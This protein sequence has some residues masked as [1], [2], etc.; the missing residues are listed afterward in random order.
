[1]LL[2]CAA[3]V[4]AG[5]VAYCDDRGA[6]S[7][8]QSQN[9]ARLTG[10]EG[11]GA[12][13]A[14]QLM[15][16]VDSRKKNSAQIKDYE[17]FTVAFNAANGTPDY[18]AWEL[19][20]SETD[21]AWSR[22]DKFWQDPEIKGCPE[23]KDYSNSGYD[24]GHL[25][26]AADQKWSPRAMQDC[27][28]MANMC[29]QAHA[30]NAGAW[31]TLEQKERLWAQR[32]SAIIIV[33]G[34]IYENSDKERIGEAGVRVPGAFFKVMLAPY[35]PE[36]RAIGF[37]YPNM[38]SPGNMQNYVMTVREVEK[39]TGLDFFSSLPDDVEEQLETTSSFRDWN[40]K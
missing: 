25:C 23:S 4:A 35:L 6:S 26:P 14:G 31:K 11:E 34:P 8:D 18:V 33:A 2:L 10:T 3:M 32:D 13:S 21:G 5:V 37:V 7:S 16:V 27:F 19:L 9:R 1:M 28:V 36:P 15:K 40:K 20:G 39:L 17:G 24:R 22:S 12:Y 29:P 38:T 30:L